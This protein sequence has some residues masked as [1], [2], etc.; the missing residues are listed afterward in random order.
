MMQETQIPQAVAVQCGDTPT[1]APDSG[2][3]PAAALTLV[4]G[5]TEGPPTSCNGLQWKW[6]RTAINENLG[7]D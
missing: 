2:E 4:V 5:G 7:P 1:P 6:V 3:L